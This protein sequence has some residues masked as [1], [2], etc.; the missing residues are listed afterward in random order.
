MRRG[1]IARS[2]TELP[3]AVFDARLERLRAAMQDLDALLV[4]TN[5]TRPAAV[6]WLTGFIPYWSEAMLVV[7]RNGL[8]VL[9]VALTFRVKPWIER[10]SRVAAVIHAPRVGIETARLIAGGKADAAV[11]VVDFDHLPLGIADDLGEAGPR[12]AMS[13][14][15]DLFAMVRA[16]ADPAEIMLTARASSIAAT[17]LSWIEPRSGAHE[18]VAAV[19]ADARR[20]GAEEV[21][22]AMAPDLAGDHRLLRVEGEP[23]LGRRF[24]VRASVAYKGSWVRRVVTVDRDGAVSDDAQ[25]VFADAVARL[26]SDCALSQF[27]AFLV[28][29]HRIAQPLEALIGSG[30]AAARPAVAGAV[31]SVQ[32]RIE[33]DGRPVLL[34]APALVGASGEAASI[35]P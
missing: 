26:P 22:V 18:I 4:Y 1:L 30:V 19:E 33:A 10:T 6:S 29:G 7:P 21:Y 12:L 28:E 15:S 14:A 16:P 2:K 24:A 13:D 5:N 23:A 3:D 32:A 31:V 25:A 17:A 20:N 11:G 35:F 8:P 34:G 27:S 9:V